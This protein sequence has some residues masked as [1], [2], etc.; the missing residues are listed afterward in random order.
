MKKGSEHSRCV[1]VCCPVP[2]PRESIGP[3]RVRLLS[4]RVACGSDLL[5]HTQLSVCLSPC[6]LRGMEKC[7]FVKANSSSLSPPW[8]DYLQE[9]EMLRKQV[10]CLAEENGKLLG[11]Q[12]PNQKIHYVV[13]LK[14]ENVRLAEVTVLNDLPVV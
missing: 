4:E 5:S 12:N 7:Y 9:V 11:H 6:A 2:G 13:R 1:C 8:V 14:R 3:T 10:E